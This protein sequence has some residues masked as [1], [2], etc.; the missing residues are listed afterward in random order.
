MESKEINVLI[1][2]SS[3][4]RHILKTCADHVRDNHIE[5]YKINVTIKF[6]NFVTKHSNLI[7][8]VLNAFITHY[9]ESYIICSSMYT[10]DKKKSFAVTSYSSIF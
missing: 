8:N 4:I 5:N 7:M 9:I 3:D 2:G 1:S 10:S 6:I